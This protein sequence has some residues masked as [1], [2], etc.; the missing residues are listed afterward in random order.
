[1]P[2]TAAIDNET[3]DHLLSVVN[4][5]S[6]IGRMRRDSEDAFGR[7]RLP[8]N[9]LTHEGRL[10]P[11][12][13]AHRRVQALERQREHPVAE[14]LLHQADRSGGPSAARHRVEPAQSVVAATRSIQTRPASSL[15]CSTEPPGAMIS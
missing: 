14:Q 9:E 15:K 12:Q 3:L 4:D 7:H 11:P 1:M 2:A 10:L 8:C 5:G 13:F 6:N